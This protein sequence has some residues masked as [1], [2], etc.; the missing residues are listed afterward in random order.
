M[1]WHHIKPICLPITPA[2]RSLQLERYTVTG[3][4]LTENHVE[5]QVLQETLVSRVSNDDCKQSL[6]RYY[7]HE[8]QLSDK[9]I[10]AEGKFLVDTCIGDSGGPL[11][12]YTE[13]HNESRFVQFG[14]FTA[15][16]STCASAP[17]VTPKHKDGLCVAIQRCQNIYNIVRSPPSANIANYIKQAACILPAVKRSICCTR[18]EVLQQ[19]LLPSD[20]GHSSTDR[21]VK[22][23]IT[24]V[25]SYPWMALLRYNQNGTIVDRCGGSLISNRYVLTV[26]HCLKK[27][28]SLNI[29]HVRLGEHTRNQEEYC[30][31]Y[32]GGI[33]D[34]AD[35]VEDYQIESFD[36]H[37]EYNRPK[38]R[39]DIGLIRLARVVEFKDHIQPICLPL[40]PE[41]RSKRLEKYIVTGWGLTENKV[42]SQILLE[43][44]I[45]SVSNDECS[46]TLAQ[47]RQN[48]QLSDKQI[49]AGGESLVD[50]C[51]GDSGEPLG[52][53]T[54]Y[55][56]KP[57][58]VQF[59][60]V[61]FGVD[62]C[63]KKSVPG[64]YCRVGSYMDWILDNIMP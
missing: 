28:P 60:V 27:T 59:G 62:S 20:C 19:S 51:K 26:A 16:V 40:S 29:D 38:Y 10:C 32:D 56:N 58:F 36:M 9:H 17:C 55:D 64:I 57:L 23:N 61:S 53:D 11:E 31:T 44:I 15:R 34:C 30:I 63:G 25:F 50:T 49:C 22:A 33:A 41:L 39:N 42:E 12:F 52:F 2:L 8:L 37:P 54:E 35:P 43:A 14:V 5:S 13:H 6:T 21:L 18:E 7:P 45:S 48:V 4:G 3:W 47:L 46:Q 24:Q 1:K